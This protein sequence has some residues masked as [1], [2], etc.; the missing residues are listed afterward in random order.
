VAALVA[1][2]EGVKLVDEQLKIK[3]S[4]WTWA[5]DEKLNDQFYIVPGLGDAG[6]LSYGEKL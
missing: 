1:A 4:I 6:D 3:N 5:L 2:P